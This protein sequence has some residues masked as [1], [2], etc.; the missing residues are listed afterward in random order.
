MEVLPSRKPTISK[1][2][3]VYAKTCQ[4]L[5]KDLLEDILCLMLCAVVNRLFL[6][7]NFFIFAFLELKVWPTE[8]PRGQ[9]SNQSCSCWPKPQP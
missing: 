4:L 8:A 1:S 9:G 6:I 3:S 5:V 7:F 2:S